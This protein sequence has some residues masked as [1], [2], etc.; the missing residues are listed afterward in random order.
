M[1]TSVGGIVE[2]SLILASLYR[3][4]RCAVAV[5]AFSAW[6]GQAGVSYFLPAM[7]GTMGITATT[8]VLDINL[9]IGIA[10]GIASCVGASLMDRF[11]RRK[12]LFSCCISLAVM[13]VGMVACTG[14]FYSTK[15]DD[16]AEASVVFVFLV[17]IAFSFAY[18]PLQQLYPVECLRFE[19]RAKGIAVASMLQ[20]AASLVNLLATPVALERI[21]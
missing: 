5:P 3:V 4:F 11:G 9:G 14:T 16:A 7:L 1:E 13:W 12:M 8:T 20:S 6:T 18:T 19:Q 21:A 17:G 10:S 2:S 15:S